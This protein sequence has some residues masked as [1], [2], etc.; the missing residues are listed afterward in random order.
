MLSAAR[1]ALKEPS[2]SGWCLMSRE[3]EKK[4]QTYIQTSAPLSPGNSGGPL[5]NEKGFVIGINTMSSVNGKDL[6]F[7]IPIERVNELVENKMTVRAWF[8][9]YVEM[10]WWLFEKTV[11]ERTKSALKSSQRLYPGET[12]KAT[13]SGTSDADFYYT[14]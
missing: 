7:A 8:E 9:K 2:R 5:V 4:E 6:N 3:I 11:D 13:C 10:Q 1:S 12:V 14:L